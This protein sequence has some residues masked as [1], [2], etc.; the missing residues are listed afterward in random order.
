M[1]RSV[2]P[3]PRKVMG[4]PTERTNRHETRS[5][6]TPLPVGKRPGVAQFH[7]VQALRHALSEAFPVLRFQVQPYTDGKIAVYLMPGFERVAY[8]SHSVGVGKLM[9]QVKRNLRE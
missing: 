3:A 7:T 1:S 9:A 4:D 6:S 5:M 8:G 2:D